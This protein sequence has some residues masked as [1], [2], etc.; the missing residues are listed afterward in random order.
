MALPD[1]SIR[2]LLEAGVHFGHHTRRWN[3]K[4]K[5]FIYG[6]KNGVHIIDLD[7]TAL[8]LDRAMEFIKLMVGQGKSIMLVSTK[9]QASKL[10]MDAARGSSMPYVINKWI[11]GL[12]TNFS[13]IKKRIKYFNDLYNSEK[14]GELEKY[15]KKE[16]SKF[17][18]ELIKLDD[19]FGGVRD[20]DK[21]P[22]MIFVA[23]VIRD[24]IVVKEANKMKIPV[25][26]I[27]DS[28]ADP[29]GIDY[30][31]PANDDASKSI[32]II[33]KAITDAFIDAI[34]SL[35]GFTLLMIFF[36]ISSIFNILL[37]LRVKEQKNSSSIN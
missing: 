7:K 10:I 35:S 23:D 6:S 19:A 30:L 15:T 33:S 14:S 36:N 27:V 21:L 8:Y 5:S 12:V 24:K 34:S 13:T 3:P 37:I 20:L 2:Q 18:K 32:K 11:P 29:N 25:I 26:A 4:M 9:P 31:I 17:K 22:Q 1:F 28:N 16:I